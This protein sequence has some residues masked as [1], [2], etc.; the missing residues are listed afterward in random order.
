MTVWVKDVDFSDRLSPLNF[1]ITPFT[2]EAAL[3]RNKSRG[4]RSA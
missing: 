4:T 3:P 1:R 2:S